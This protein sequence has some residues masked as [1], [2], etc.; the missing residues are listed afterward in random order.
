MRILAEQAGAGT[1]T[2]EGEDT[3]VLMLILS[4]GYRIAYESAALMLQDHRQDRQDFHHQLLE[5][6][7]GLAASHFV[8]LRHLPRVLPDLLRLVPAMVGYSANVK[9]KSVSTPLNLPARL[10]EWQRMW[11]LKGTEDYISSLRRQV[12]ALPR[13]VNRERYGNS[14]SVRWGQA[15]IAS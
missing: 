10:R 4:T 8:L 2:P 9:V 11:K 6:G 13:R 3:T 15:R 5:C 14:L 1:P 12:R 7:C